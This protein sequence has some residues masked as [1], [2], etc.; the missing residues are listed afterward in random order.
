MMETDLVSVKFCLKK[1][2]VMD[3]IPNKVVFC[4]MTNKCAII[5]Q[6][7]TLLHV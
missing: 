6:I 2:K 1:P 3:S 7:I 5:S 4:T